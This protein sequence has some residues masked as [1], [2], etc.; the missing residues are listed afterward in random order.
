MIIQPGIYKHYKGTYYDV[1]GTV[2]HSETAEHLVLY[3]ALYCAD[4][5]WVRPL[6]MFLQEVEFDGKKVRRFEKVEYVSEK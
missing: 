4:V 3:K 6:N 1:V 5:L 2:K